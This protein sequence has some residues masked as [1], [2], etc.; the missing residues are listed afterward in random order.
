MV[1]DVP[2]DTGTTVYRLYAVGGGEEGWNASL[3]TLVPPEDAPA[4]LPRRAPGE[5]V[6][7]GPEYAPWGTDPF[8]SPDP[9]PSLP[10]RAERGM[11]R[12]LKAAGTDG[13][14]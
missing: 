10:V 1:I 9:S 2:G 12:F 14:S 13:A 4:P 5:T 11:E 3:D 8:G 6:Q 7:K